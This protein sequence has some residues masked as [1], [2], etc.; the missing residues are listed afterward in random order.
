MNEYSKEELQNLVK[1]LA[2]N[3]GYGCYTRQGFELLVWAGIAE[4]AKWIIFFDVDDM[5]ALNRKHSYEG[6]N[7]IIKAQD[8]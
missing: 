1:A 4:K 8:Q 6:M 3:E 7:A 5:H 2:W